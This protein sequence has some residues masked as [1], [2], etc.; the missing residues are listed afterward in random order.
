ME[1]VLKPGEGDGK[2]HVFMS[3]S[4]KGLLRNNQT[5][6]SFTPLPVSKPDPSISTASA[7]VGLDGKLLTETAGALPSVA[8][9][10]PGITAKAK[11]T[12]KKAV[13]NKSLCIDI[14]LG[15]F[16]ILISLQAA[17]LAFADQLLAL[18]N[19]QDLLPEV[20]P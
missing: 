3:I 4:V 2:V 9:A 8:L 10:E 14:N 19:L 11:I 17:R 15:I 1:Q 5:L 16:I 20:L 6:I 13:S 7:V 18:S 12:P